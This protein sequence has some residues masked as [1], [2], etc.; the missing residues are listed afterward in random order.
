VLVIDKISF[1]SAAS[2]N[3]ISERLGKVFPSCAHLLFGGLHF[4]MC[5]DRFQ[6]SPAEARPLRPQKKFPSVPI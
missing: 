5:G 3:T 2:L 6:L 4:L 1:V